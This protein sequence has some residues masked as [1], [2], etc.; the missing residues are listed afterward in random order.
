MYTIHMPLDTHFWYQI[1]DPAQLHW[2]TEVQATSTIW[3]SSTLTEDTSMMTVFSCGVN[4][5]MVKRKYKTA[6]DNHAVVKKWWFILRGSEERLQQLE[7]EWEPVAIHTSWK[8]EP[9]YR[10]TCDADEQ[11]GPDKEC[12]KVPADNSKNVNSDNEPHNAN[13]V[14]ADN[15]KNVNSDNEPHNANKV[16]ADNSKNVNSDNESH[17]ANTNLTSESAS[18][19][20]IMQR[21]PS[22]CSSSSFLG[23]Q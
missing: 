18:P 3:W 14:P 5:I 16:P 7:N 6:R 8:I 21:S 22:N 1:I 15:S 19:P 12:D 10:F 20:E 11:H 2:A 23:H 13:K 4:L 17:N 9:A